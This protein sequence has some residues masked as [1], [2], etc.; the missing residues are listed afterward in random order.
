M[1]SVDHVIAAQIES[2]DK[3]DAQFVAI[4]DTIVGRL[5]DQKLAFRIQIPPRLVG[6]H[7]ANRGGYGVSAVEVH[8]LGAGHRPHGVV[9]GRNCACGLHRRL[10][11]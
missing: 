6:V 9:V 10:P 4:I 8:A 11:R 5:Q 2:I 1:A 3:E 7:P